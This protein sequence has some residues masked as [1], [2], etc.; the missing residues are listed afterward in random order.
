MNRRIVLFYI[1][2]S[3]GFAHAMKNEI[4]PSNSFSLSS[5]FS[6]VSELFCFGPVQ[7]ESELVLDLRVSKKNFEDNLIDRETKRELCG[8]LTM[9]TFSINSMCQNPVQFLQYCYCFRHYEIMLNPS[10]SDLEDN[11]VL[12]ERC[13]AAQK[14]G[15]SALGAVMIAENASIEEKYNFIQK[16][17]KYGFKPTL[18]DIQLARLFLYDEIIK[19]EWKQLI[20]TIIA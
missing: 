7:H 16:L 4:V 15:Y 20:D 5:L 3:S 19:K 8:C 12:L 9:Q 13:L 6:A 18:K 17:I 1:V 10:I 11:P 14:D 2:L